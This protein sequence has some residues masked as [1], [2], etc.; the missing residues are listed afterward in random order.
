MVWCP[1]CKSGFRMC[2]SVNSC[3]FLYN[4]FD[5]DQKRK[6]QECRREMIELPFVTILQLRDFS[7]SFLN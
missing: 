6:G 2:R 1:D 5:V 3:V 4:R 7:S